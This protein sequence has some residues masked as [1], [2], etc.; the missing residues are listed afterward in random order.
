MNERF[1]T[2]P[3]CAYAEGCKAPLTEVNISPRDR[4]ILGLF[5][6]APW[7]EEIPFGAKRIF[8]KNLDWVQTKAKAEGL[9][10]PWTPI[11]V[12]RLE[13]CEK[14][15]LDQQSEKMELERQQEEMQGKK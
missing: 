13:I 9:R 11:V 3:I 12:K 14:L 7:V 15:I 6:N 10:I 1:S 5:V 8:R 2:D 4:I